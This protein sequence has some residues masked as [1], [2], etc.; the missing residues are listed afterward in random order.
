M[1]KYRIKEMIIDGIKYYKLQKR[2]LWL[3]WIDVRLPVYYNCSINNT[4]PIW[5]IIYWGENNDEFRLLKVKQEPKTLLPLDIYITTTVIPKTSDIESIKK[6]KIWLTKEKD[7]D[8]V[9]AGYILQHKDYRSKKNDIG[10]AY[11]VKCVPEIE[12]GMSDQYFLNTDIIS[13]EYCVGFKNSKYALE[14]GE[15][16]NDTRKYFNWRKKQAIKKQENRYSP[17]TPSYIR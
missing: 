15:K 9:K 6:L 17:T 2:I 11:I 1:E 10:I 8:L 12:K 13:Q 16:S 3:F 7:S 4:D 5:E 14:E